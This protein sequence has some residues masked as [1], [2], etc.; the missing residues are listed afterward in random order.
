MRSTFRTTTAL[1][2]SL[3]LVGGNLP[4][5]ALAQEVDLSQCRQGESEADCRA[6][7]LS[8]L[9]AAEQAAGD[10]A[11]SAETGGEDQGPPAAEDGETPG[12]QA[13]AETDAPAPQAEEGSGE[14]E[15]VGQEDAAAP[16][17]QADADVEADA[18]AEQGAVAEEGPEN[19]A[20]DAAAEEDPVAA[21]AESDIEPE[22][23]GEP[24]VSE[25]A[26]SN[27]EAP[28][29]EP[30]ITTDEASESD[31]AEAPVEEE[32]T[33]AEAL[34]T[35]EEDSAVTIDGATPSDADMA[36][37]EAARAAAEAAEQ[38]AAEPADMVAETEAEVARAE[39]EAE[40]A[41][42]SL[43][44]QSE[45][46][47]VVASEQETITEESVRSSAE[48]FGTLETESAAAEPARDRSGLTGVQG[49]ILGGIAGLA[50]GSV[51]TG[52]RQVVN[53]ADDRIVVL[54][55]Q[56][57]YQVIRDDDTLLR[58]P[59]SNVSTETFGDGSSRTV[60]TQP[61]GTQVITVRDRDLRI[62]RR[63][64]V[65]PDGTRTVLIDDIAVQTP[66][67]VSD[68]P[69]AELSERPLPSASADDRE[70]LARA[71]E[72]QAA[73]DR[74]FSLAQI[75]SIR[76]VRALAPAVNLENLTFATGSAA[77]TADQASQLLALGRYMS[78]AIDRNPREIFLIEGHTDATG[79]A[80]FNLA[81]SDRRAETVALALTEYF[82][83]PPQ[84]MVIQGYGEEYLLIP[85]LENERLNRR[86]A[87]RRITDLLRVAAAE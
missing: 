39:E 24:A 13:D 65:A 21:E 11:P 76:A 55:P 38:A 22:G 6:R 66:V 15:A 50:I 74:G 60:V 86:V 4:V 56:G 47:P 57:D 53:Q 45:A 59:G 83:V 44:L 41:Q 63:T 75:R 40:A 27:A 54:R 72:A 46:E 43:A 30:T 33:L 71:L 3:S 85:T 73:V 25:D 80:A 81:L 14:A 20:A 8:E 52:N 28:E 79:S 32:D 69:T 19:A 61:D 62:L 67:V 36:E 87:V 58:R 17:P 82:D 2:A 29:T 49:L 26:P 70:A 77:I 23:A 12:A 78:E 64:V 16:E 1:I 42:Q 51:I 18:Q 9:E 48:E 34:Q 10:E 35:A 7:I 68:L 5:T 37:L 84:N 31:A